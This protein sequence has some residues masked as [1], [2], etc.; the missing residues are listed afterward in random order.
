MVMVGG[1]GVACAKKR[2]ISFGGE[3]ALGAGTD[4]QCHAGAGDFGDMGA[5]FDGESCGIRQNADIP[6]APAGADG[7]AGGQWPLQCE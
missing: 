7:M 1:H 3:V 6:S 5:Q 2:W 4:P